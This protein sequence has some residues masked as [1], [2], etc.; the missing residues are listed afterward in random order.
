MKPALL[1][2]LAIAAVS[3]LGDYLWANVI[4]HRIAFYGLV[5]G[6]VLFL[7]VGLCLGLP[8]RK[9]VAGA[10][11]GAVVGLSSAGLFYVIQPIV[12]YA[13]AIFML[14][15][16]LWIELG[17]LTGRV[18]QHRDSIRAVLLRS[19]LAAV[20]SGLGFYAISGI[21]FPFN[22]HGWDYAVHFVYWTLAYLPGFLALLWHSPLRRSS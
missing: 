3:T 21:W 15:F 8:A 14:F 4:P 5:H 7:T 16:A 11:G 9:P 1:G 6:L 13:P 18:L 17:L 10:V 2:A 22:P 20:G 19:V 12:G